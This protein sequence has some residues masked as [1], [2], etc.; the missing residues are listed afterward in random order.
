M[1]MLN[2]TPVL[3]RDFIRE[4]WTSPTPSDAEKALANSNLAEQIELIKISPL[5]LNIEEISKLWT[6]IQA[7]Y[8]P[9]AAYRVSVVLIEGTRPA[10]T[11]LP[12]LKRGRDVSRAGGRRPTLPIPDSRVTAAV[13]LA[14]GRAPR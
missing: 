8:R 9:T 11:P 3:T 4:T 5:D 1:Q 7:K 2:E 10:W 6:A 13:P 14:A 12:V